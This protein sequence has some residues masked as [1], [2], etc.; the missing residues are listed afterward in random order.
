MAGRAR[1]ARAMINS[2]H[3]NLPAPRPAARPQKPSREVEPEGLGDC[4]E[5]AARKVAGFAVGLVF[6]TSGML[7]NACAGGAQGVVHGARLEKGR[8]AAFQGALTANLAAVSAVGG[9]PVGAVLGTVGGHLMWRVQGEKVR[10]RVQRG[11]DKWVDAVL[12]KL[13]GNPDEAG[14]GR[15]ALNGAIGEVVGA[16]GGVVAGTIGL[17]QAGQKAGE[18]FVERTADRL[19]E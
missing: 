15:R 3:S 12:E 4:V 7:V 13:P 11:S 17:F 6:G 18:A 2:L 10:E 16:A 5:W 1:Y 19:R 14:A 9:G 8:E